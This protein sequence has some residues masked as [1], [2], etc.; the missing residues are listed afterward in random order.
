[1]DETMRVLE[2]A[3]QGV[4]AF[5]PGSSIGPRVLDDCEVLW[6]IAGE[7]R[8]EVDGRE[9]VVGAG[10]A[11]VAPP[12]RL[13][14]WRYEQPGTRHAF[15]HLRLDPVG[16]RRLARRGPLVRRLP[17]ADIVRPL[18]RHLGWLHLQRPPG[19]R[20]LACGAAGQLLAVLLADAAGLG[21]E[22]RA[23]PDPLVER[24]FACLRRRWRDRADAVPVAAL[25]R[26]LGLSR[27]QLARTVSRH[28]GMPVSDLLRGLRLDRAVGL[29]TDTDLAVEEVAART[30]FVSAAHFSRCVRAAC[31]RPPRALRAAYR[32]GEA[33]RLRSVARSAGFA[34]ALRGRGHGGA[35]ST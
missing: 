22:G 29:L 1:M 14:R 31:G 35:P 23:P 7:A 9:L 28:C 11:A 3:A 21:D 32:A 25:A 13:E 15:A 8:W 33:V 26:E 6:V 19:W 10:M 17:D 24:L 2:V 16:Y 30:G 12:G 27:S 20:A 18:F 34:P 5:P 4:A